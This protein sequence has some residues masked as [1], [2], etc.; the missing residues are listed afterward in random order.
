VPSLHSELKDRKTW[1]APTPCYYGRLLRSGQFQLPLIANN[2]FPASP[3]VERHSQDS[4][5]PRIIRLYRQ[6]FLPL[7]DC[8]VDSG[9]VER[10]HYRSCN[11]RRHNQVVALT[12]A[13]SGRSP[14]WSPSLSESVGQIHMNESRPEVVTRL[15]LARSNF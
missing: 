1:P 6:S 11:R 9:L 3:F 7:R 4:Y 14:L 12:L 2:P 15:T 13:R 8:I 5:G 10:A